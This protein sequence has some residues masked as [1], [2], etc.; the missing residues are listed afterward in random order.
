MTE[1]D[2]QFDDEVKA[3]VEKQRAK[4]KH[5]DWTANMN[6]G[7]YLVLPNPSADVVQ[8]EQHDSPP[9]PPEESEEEKLQR[10]WGNYKNAV[11]H[12]IYSE[13]LD[14]SQADGVEKLHQKML[15]KWTTKNA[16]S[17]VDIQAL[18]QAEARAAFED[19]MERQAEMFGPGE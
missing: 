6:T 5:F 14:C 1:N 8:H 7:S 10:I 2:Q 18:Q 4:D 15:K 16:A 17:K 11:A 9:P 3:L 12:G 13:W 19:A